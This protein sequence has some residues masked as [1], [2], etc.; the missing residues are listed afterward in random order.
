VIEV[1]DM[2]KRNYIKFSILTFAEPVEKAKTRRTTS[3][4]S[5]TLFL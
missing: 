4:F 2:G 1:A 3:I 5:A